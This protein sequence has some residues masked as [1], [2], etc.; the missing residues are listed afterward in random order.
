MGTRTVGVVVFHTATV[1]L[2]EVADELTISTGG[3]RIKGGHIRAIR[4]GDGLLAA[5]ALLIERHGIFIGCPLGIERDGSCQVTDMRTR[6][7]GIIVLRT[8][9][10]LL[11][12]IAAEGIARVGGWYYVWHI[13]A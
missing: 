6:A 4:G 9:T 2:S 8:A 1:L 3:H 10:I 11:C 5:T 12:V 13:I 7:V